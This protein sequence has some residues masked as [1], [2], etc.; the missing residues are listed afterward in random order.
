M[1]FFGDNSQCSWMKRE[2]LE[3]W[4]CEE[5]DVRIAKK[6]KGLQSAI[7]EANA[8]IDKI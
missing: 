5:Y 6:T 2:K 4:L 3:P 8:A 1:V 7:A